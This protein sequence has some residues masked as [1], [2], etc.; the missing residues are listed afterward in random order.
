MK[1]WF[2]ILYLLYIFNVNEKPN[3]ETVMDLFIKIFS[4]VS[5]KYKID[6][7]NINNK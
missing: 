2:N 1:F 6:K 4:K 3:S 7:Q 5:N